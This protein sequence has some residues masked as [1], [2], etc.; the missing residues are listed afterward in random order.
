VKEERDHSARSADEHAAFAFLREPL[1]HFLLLGALLF[2][3]HRLFV[4]HKDAERVVVVPRALASE[5]AAEFRA[6][7]GRAPE[8]AELSAA[9][10]KWKRDEVAYREGMRL[11]LDKN[12]PVVRERVADKLRQVESKLGAARQ[13][14]DAELDA[15]LVAHRERYDTPARYDFEHYFASK[16]AGDAE[17]RARRILV[18][19]TEG[20]TP[21]DVGDAFSE[22]R[23]LIGR[24][25]G[26][27]QR[28]FGPAFERG[29]EG[30]AVGQWSLLESAAGFHAVRLQ[31]RVARQPAAREARRAE[32]TRDLLSAEREQGSSAALQALVDSYVFEEER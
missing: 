25:E 11:G 18:D 21:E 29:L 1:M 10:D 24:S 19:L 9:V 14:S 16:Q 27:V 7:A 2:V 32:L 26:D 31:D 13:P 28:L 20:R 6:K 12:D 3:A 22:G 17:G 8:P 23:Q 15:W 4:A 5:L 30:L